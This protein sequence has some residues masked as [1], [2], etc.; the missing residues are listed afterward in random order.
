V[1]TALIGKKFENSILIMADK[2]ITYRGTL[3]FHDNEKKIIV[4][5]EKIIF[6]YAGIK[7]IIDIGIDS[8]KKYSQSIHSVE[9]IIHQS[10]RIYSQSLS[11]FKKSYPGQNDATVFIL[12]GFKD[13]GETFSY[14]FSSADH[15]KK[16]YP[17]D[18]FYKTFPDT[19]MLNL[20]NYLKYQVDLSRNDVDYFIEKFSSAIKE[21]NNN[22]ISRSVY[23]IYLT[24]D[25]IAEIDINEKGEYKIQK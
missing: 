2:R 4:L 1:L 3:Q 10:Q 7:N 16:R 13:S 23:S 21:I 19:E 11:E 12:S 20:G 9:K 5:N 22:K 8:L 17:L 14:Y 6:A 25:K 18:F 15:F 24:K